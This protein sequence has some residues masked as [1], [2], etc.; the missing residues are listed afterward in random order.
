MSTGGRRIKKNLTIEEIEELLL[1]TIGIDP[2]RALWLTPR[3]IGAIIR[4]WAKK[5]RLRFVTQARAFGADISA[6]EA[7]AIIDD[8]RPA[9]LTA[10]EKDTRL[11]SIIARH[12]ERQRRRDATSNEERS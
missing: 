8:T 3:E 11:Q 7:Q 10:E 12:E 5:E 9:Q 4:G 1:G 2:E 6:D